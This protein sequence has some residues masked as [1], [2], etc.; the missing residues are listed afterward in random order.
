MGLLKSAFSAVIQIHSQPGYLK[1]LGTTDIY[2]PIRTAPSNYFRYL[3]GPSHTVVTGSELILPV[4]TIYGQQRIDATIDAAPS[5]GTWTISFDLNG[6]TQ[7]SASLDFDADMTDIQTTLRLI[8]GCEA[9]TVTGDLQAEAVT[10]NFIGVKSVQN[11]SIDLTSL[12]GTATVAYAYLPIAWPT[13]AVKRGDRL[14]LTG[15]SFTATE[16]I[17]MPDLGGEVIGYRVRFE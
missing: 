2:S 4:S 16:V 13:P 17:E 10:I 1:R 9:V 11:L 8:A 14:L 5:A 7:T 3:Q 15:G 6:S 12:T